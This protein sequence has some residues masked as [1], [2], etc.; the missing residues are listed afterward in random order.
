[1]TDCVNDDRDDLWID[2]GTFSSK[3][4]L[5]ERFPKQSWR[6]QHL[7][8]E[9]YSQSGNMEKYAASLVSVIEDSIFAFVSASFS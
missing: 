6:L 7:S 8:W 4:A 5:N 1:M 3:S 2:S 9:I